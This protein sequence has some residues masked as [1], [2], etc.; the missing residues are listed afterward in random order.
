M[1]EHYDYHRGLEKAKEEVRR[2]EELVKR[3]KLLNALLGLTLM[4]NGLVS[5]D[6]VLTVIEHLEPE[7]PDIPD[8]ARTEFMN[9]VYDELHSDGDNNRANRIINAADEYVEYSL[10]K[11]SEQPKKRTEEHKW[12]TCFDCL[13]SH[14]C[15]KIKGCTNEQA[16]EYASQIPNDCPL[17]AQP[18]PCEDAVSRDSANYY[19]E[20]LKN[21]EHK[22]VEILDVFTKAF[23]IDAEAG[24]DLVFRC[25]E[26][27]FQ[28]IDGTCLVKAF[29]HKFDPDYKDFGSMG[30]L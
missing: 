19:S 15:P 24:N 16:I 14:G 28:T 12:E 11:Q 5:I 4:E 8:D 20:R 17:S 7:Y 9:L 2:G 18:E 10:A 22:A 6:A 25:P 23:C 21:D 13:L 3:G 27:L 30:D 26:C 29:K 1:S